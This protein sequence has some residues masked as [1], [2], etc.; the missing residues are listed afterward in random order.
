MP[1]GGSPF[2]YWV[3]LDTGLSYWQRPPLAAAR[4]GTPTTTAVVGLWS[5][6]GV[7]GVAVEGY[8]SPLPHKS[9]EEA[10][11]V[12]AFSAAGGASGRA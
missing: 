8:V 10:D 11:R 6:R 7:A 5:P 4:D 1:G 9:T 12:A 3:D 2:V